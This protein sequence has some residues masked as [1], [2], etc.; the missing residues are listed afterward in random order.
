MSEAELKISELSQELKPLTEKI[1]A[2]ETLQKNLLAFESK[3]D[4]IKTR[5]KI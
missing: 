2:I 4:K 1:N 3:R 5:Y